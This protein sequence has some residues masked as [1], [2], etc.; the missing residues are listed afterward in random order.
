MVPGGFGD[1]GITGKLEAIRYA[2]ENGVP[3]FGIC[4][5]M[6]AA[7][8][9]FARHVCGLEKAHSREF[10]TEETT[11]FVI[12]VM[13]GQ[14]Q[15]Q[16]KGGSMRLG[17]YACELTAS[18]KVREIYKTGKIHE[19]HRHRYEF[20]STYKELFEKKGMTIAGVYKEGKESL[21]EILEI[22]SHP[23][24][25]GV[26]FHPEFRSKPTAPHPLFVSFVK[27]G[28]LR[29]QNKSV[30]NPLSGQRLKIS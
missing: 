22:P 7:A 8:I 27:A 29:R 17:S 6:Q 5:G 25:I 13:P 15:V 12:D 10:E 14:K 28:L 30:K 3:F 26:Q 2:R 16:R 1:R 19:R 4:L 11:D 24:F 18:S 20:N 23:W 21:V 9:E